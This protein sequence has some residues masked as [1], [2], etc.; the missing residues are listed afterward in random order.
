MLAAC[1][2]PVTRRPRHTPTMRHHTLEHRIRQRFCRATGW[3]ISSAPDVS[4]IVGLPMDKYQVALEKEGGGL[5]LHHKNCSIDHIV[6]L[7]LFDLYNA[8]EAAAAFHYRNT[9]LLSMQKNQA[10]GSQFCG[11]D[12]L[13]AQA[14]PDQAARLYNMHHSGRLQLCPDTTQHSN[15]VCCKPERIRI[16]GPRSKLYSLLLLPAH[17]SRPLP[18]NRCILAS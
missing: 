5:R 17:R 2:M 10:K 11:W 15:L 16:T 18:V 7:A 14:F 1:L 6:P 12:P 3:K 13:W 8:R 9:R 4:R